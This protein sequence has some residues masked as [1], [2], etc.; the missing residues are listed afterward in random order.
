MKRLSTNNIKEN[1]SSFHKKYL[2]KDAIKN[3]FLNL[4]SSL[5][6]TPME[7]AAGAIFWLF[8]WGVYQWKVESKRA[9]FIPLAFSEIEQVEK[10]IKDRWDTI[11]A[12]NIYSL[13][14]NDLCMKIF[15]AYNESHWYTPY[16]EDKSD[17]FG[18]R[19]YECV[20]LKH[21]YKYNLDDLLEQVPEHIKW[22]NKTIKTY[23]D[24]DHELDPIINNLNATWDDYHHDNYHT[25]MRSRTVTD[26]KWKSHTE[27]YTVQ[28]YDNTTHTY[29]YNKKYGEQVDYELNNLVKKHPII[30]LKEKIIKTDKTNA[31]GEFAADKSR[32]RLADRLS[33]KELLDAANS[34]YNWSTLLNHIKIIDS[35]YPDLITKTKEWSVAKKSAKSDRYKTNTHYDDGPE[36]FQTIENTLNISNE[37]NNNIDEVIQVV[38]ETS[39]KIP[40]LEKK[41]DEYIKLW[42]T[43]HKTSDEK[44]E[45]IMDLTKDIYVLNFKTWIEVE[46]FRWLMVFLISLL[47]GAIGAWLWWVLDYADNKYKLYNQLLWYI[48]KKQK[49]K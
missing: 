13:K 30:K 15:E 1:I 19:L 48:S 18:A 12:I 38:E 10:N 25:E 40:L 35:L 33:P 45:E 28:V 2:S 23:K 21:I 4:K 6:T 5:E 44:A 24:V 8:V 14:V 20:T 7:I 3:N 49:N 47:W 37:I 16:T 26:S 31:F 43:Y 17:V 39:K 29:D 46:R 41:I 11:W 34:W 9:E 32:Q 36:E 42:Y 22:V 27:Y